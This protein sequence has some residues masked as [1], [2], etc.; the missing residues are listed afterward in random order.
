[1]PKPK[2]DWSVALMDTGI[3]SKTQKR[4]FL[5]KNAIKTDRFMLTYGDGVADINI[6]ELVRRHEYLRQKHGVLGTITLHS[7]R[8]KFG[9]VG[10]DGDLAREFIEKPH[11]DKFVNIGFMLF[12]KEVFDH[13]DDSD[14]M[15]ETSMIPRLAKEGRIGFYHHQG[16]WGYM[17]T[18]GDYL[19][20]NELWNRERPWKI[21]QD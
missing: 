16:F 15:L 20:L 12:E 17:D 14:V 8:S 11:Q 2:E 18:Y 4:L 10:T 1:M 6:S 9:I 19:H 7:P 3:D 21:W 13:I 5:A